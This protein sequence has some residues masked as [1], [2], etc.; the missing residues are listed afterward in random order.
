MK[1][2]KGDAT[3]EQKDS[4]KAHKHRKLTV[5]TLNPDTNRQY[6]ETEPREDER[7]TAG[8]LY[9]SWGHERN[10]HHWSCPVLNKSGALQRER[11]EKQR[12]AMA[13]KNTQTHQGHLI[14]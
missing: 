7:H 6:K 4:N 14:G 12:K 10:C 1:S 11:D 9:F 2:V 8:L 5:Q 13:D 3:G